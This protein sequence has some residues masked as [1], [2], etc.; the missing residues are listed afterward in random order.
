[1]SL[2]ACRSCRLDAINPHAL[3]SAIRADDPSSS[4]TMRGVWNMRMASRRYQEMR[5]R[6]EQDGFRRRHVEAP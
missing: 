4:I 2:H 5:E 1:M 6:A 3:V